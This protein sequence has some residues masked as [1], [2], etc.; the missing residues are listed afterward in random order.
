M[1]TKVDRQ[2]ESDLALFARILRQ[3]RPYWLHI[4]ALFLIS[5]LATPV[6]L[7]NPV[8][9]KIAVDSVLGS[10]P[11]P[12]LLEPIVPQA[13]QSSQERLLILAALLVIAIALLTHLQSLGKSLLRS[14]VG[15]KLILDFRAGLFRHAQRLSLAYHDTKGTA[16][17][18]YRIQYDTNAVQYVAIDGVIPFVT[19]GVTLIAMFW[20]T[21]HLDL[22]L[23]LI[24]LGVTPF[25]TVYTG[26]YRRHVR[27]RYKQLKRIESSGL[28]VVQEVLT[29]LRVVKAFGQEDREQSR[30]MRHHRRGLVARLKLMMAEGGLSTL[31]GV[32]T[33]V[34]TAAVLFVGVRHVQTGVLTLG[35]LL[36]V[37]SY[38]GQLYSPIKT[39]GRKVAGL[40]NYL[41]SAERAF[42]L[43]D[44]TPEVVDKVNAR[45]LSKA[46]GEISFREVSFSY[47]EGPPVLEGVSFRIAVGEKVGIAGETGAGKSTLVSL[48]TRFYDPSEGEVRLDGVDMREY[49]LSDLRDQFAI[50]LQDT[51]LFST[52]I[53]ENISY[54]RPG[55]RDEE[56]EAAARAANAHDFIVEL[57]DG[58]DT[59]VGEKGMRLSG[60]ERQRIALARAFLKDS[61][62]LI[63]DEPTSSVDIDTEALIM[64][65][66]ERLMEGRTTLMIAHRLGTLANC[67]RLLVLE[68]GRVKVNTTDVDAGLKQLAARAKRAVV[69]GIS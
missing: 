69:T 40:Q 21:A 66:M 28:S 63:L 15:E 56:L 26:V 22:H 9:L 65:A 20:V 6:A 19:S 8:P 55:A 35:E 14:Y 44:R 38:L 41:A 32:T 43:L 12:G 37:M 57:P 2:P 27:P 58:Y 10:D 49:R 34:A 62:I 59:G 68:D 1:S 42:G 7:L 11:L 53:A 50:V 16:D 13:L 31:T 54:A 3:A 23:A 4:L 47:P 29:S 46:R 18:I 64:E 39:I 52:T 45:S 36:L 61:P 17:S 48:A 30:F 5:L 25:L 51:V 60:G 67:D 33:A 24:A